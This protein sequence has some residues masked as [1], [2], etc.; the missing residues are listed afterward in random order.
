MIKI[1]QEIVDS[2]VE[3]EKGIEERFDD[4]IQQEIVDSPVEQE[5]ELRKDLMIKSNKR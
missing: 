5:K 3:E 4:Q 1:Q 2:P